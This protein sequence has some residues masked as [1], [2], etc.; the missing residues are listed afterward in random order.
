MHTHPPDPSRVAVQHAMSAWQHQTKNLEESTSN[1]IQNCTQDFTLAMA[2][3][4][5]KKE[6]LARIIRRK[7]KALDGDDVP[8]DMWQ[9]THGEQFLA[10][11]NENLDLYVFITDKNLDVL[12]QQRHWFCDG[13]FNSMPNGY[14]TVPVMYCITRRLKYLRLHLQVP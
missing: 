2:G 10:L 8:D 9:T 6:T 11:H 5:P 12:A 1:I 14:R 7:Q 3:S 4:L 13:T